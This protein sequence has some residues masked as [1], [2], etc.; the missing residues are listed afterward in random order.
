MYNINDFNFNLPENLIAQHPLKT[1]SQS[2][3]LCLNRTTGEI[4]HQNF[5]NLPGF[6]KPNDLLIF[7]DTKV[8]PARLY[9]NKLTGGKIEILVERII[10][11]NKILAHVKAN[12][13]LKSGAK[14]QL[15]NTINAEVTGKINDLYE[16]IFYLNKSDSTLL[17][18]FEKYGHIPLPPYIQHEPSAFDKERY[19]TIFAKNAGA[20]A[21]PT[22]AL[23]F[24]EKLLE[25]IKEKNVKID[26][27]TLHVGAGTFQPVRVKNILEHKMH[28]EYAEVS[29]E[30]V[31]KIKDT[32]N[33]GGRVIAVGTTTVRTLET[34]AKKNV[35]EFKGETNI[36]IY[37]GFEFKLVDAMITNF[38]FPKSTLLMLVSAFAGRENILNAYQSAI[39]N[40]Y[41]FFSFGDAMFIS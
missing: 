24:D 28:S 39:E 26:F 32:K 38:H 13:T 15:E 27:V 37:P 2:K 11:E 25:T 23:H 1:R 14:L 36:F 22:A 6:L 29:A 7:N 40:Q 20:V 10:A 31:A 19:Q 18:L 5:I 41:R 4:N 35:S 3:L 21:A 30:T 8:I 17:H 12:K 16:I 34:V 9:G 33:N